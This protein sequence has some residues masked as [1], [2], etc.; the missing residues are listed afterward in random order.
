MEISTKFKKVGKSLLSLLSLTAVETK[1]MVVLFLNCK[2][3]ADKSH[4]FIFK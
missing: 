4:S 3:F 1:L 2:L